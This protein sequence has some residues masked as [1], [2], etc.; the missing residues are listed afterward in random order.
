MSVKQNEIYKILN[1]DYFKS[2]QKILEKQMILIF[3]FSLIFKGKLGD[4]F[5][6]IECCLICIKYQVYSLHKVKSREKVGMSI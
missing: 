3:P 4:F 2:G 5:S 1:M 6:M